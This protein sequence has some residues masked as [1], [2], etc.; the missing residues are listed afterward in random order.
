[1][2]QLLPCAKGN[3]ARQEATTLLSTRRNTASKARGAFAGVRAE[4]HA[5]LIDGARAADSHIHVGRRSSQI[6]SFPSVLVDDV[7]DLLLVLRDKHLHH[8]SPP[9][10]PRRFGQRCGLSTIASKL[11]QNHALAGRWYCPA[12]RCEDKFVV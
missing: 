2:G 9:L 12:M 7:G 1:M 4:K 5:C 8:R 10:P 11:S 3:T 6:R